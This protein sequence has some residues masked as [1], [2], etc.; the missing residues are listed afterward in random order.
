[1][2]FP[3]FTKRVPVAWLSALLIR[4]FSELPADYQ[5]HAEQV[6]GGLIADMVRR[7]DRLPNYLGFLYS[8]AVGQYEDQRL[9][10]IDISGIGLTSASTGRVSV[11]VLL[12]CGIPMGIYSQIPLAEGDIDLDRI[13]VEQVKITGPV[14]SHA[15][16]LGRAG[17]SNLN[18]TDVYEVWMGGTRLLHLRDLDD[19]DF[20]ALS[21]TELCVVSIA[22]RRVTTVPAV[23]AATIKDRLHDLPASAFFAA[24][25]G[26]Y[27]D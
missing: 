14:G 8:D 12:Y 3:F 25:E 6:R 20:V 2:A 27:V 24:T 7:R 13:D 26:H 17:V 23:I 10:Y 11:G 21:G 22:E 15:E 16:E 4:I 18:A 9:P 19:G 1:M 5:V